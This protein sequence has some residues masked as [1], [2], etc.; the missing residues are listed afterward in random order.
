MRLILNFLGV[1][2]VVWRRLVSHIGLLIAIMAGFVVAVALVTSIPI[3]AEAVGFRILRDQLSKGQD[4]QIHPPFAFMYRYIGSQGGPITWDAYTP[5]DQFMRQQAPGELGLPVEQSVRY[6]ST[7]KVRM[8]PQNA[9][10]GD[11]LMWVNLA[12]ATDLESQIDVVDGKF[13]TATPTKDGPIEV[14][15]AEKRAN[16][17]G[18]QVGEDYD[19]IGPPNREP[20]LQLTVRIAGIWHP[21]DPDGGYWFYSP[22]AF[23]DAL[24]VSEETFT[25]R[26]APTTK[27]PIYTALWYMVM[28]GDGV[29]SSNVSQ[30][31]ANINRSLTDVAG[32]LP[33]VSIALSPYQALQGHQQQVRFLRILLT[34]FSLPLLG[35]VAY[36]I[37]LVA[38]MVVQQQQNEIAVLRSRGTSRLQV[39]GIYLLESIVLGLAAL[40]CGP[41]L[42]LQAARLMTWTRSFLNFEPSG[43]LPI[44]LTRQVWT[45][46]A[47]VVTLALLSSLLPALIA[48]RFTIVSYKL[49]RARSVRPP[50][51]QRLFLD[52]LLLVP[53]YYGYRQLA[54]RGTISFLGVNAPGGDP[55]QNPLLLLVPTL[56]VFALALVSLRLFPMIMSSL[57]WLCA[58][59]PGASILMALRYLARTTRGYTGP[60]MLLIITMSLATF[61]SSMSRTLDNQ[62]VDRAYYVSGSD[63]RM[64][65]LGE[66]TQ[67]STGGFGGAPSTGPGTMAGNQ[68]PAPGT[69]S[70]LD[71]ARWLFVPVT[72]YLTIPGIEAAT[73]VGR[74]DIEAEF[75]GSFEKGA[76][77]G[78]DRAD[79]PGVVGGAFRNDY[80]RDSLGALLNTLADDPAALLVS[81][82]YMAKHGL[83]V[84]D[85]VSLSMNNLGAVQKV[86]FVVVGN[87]NLFPTL[88][89]DQ[90]FFIGNLD[91]AF[92]MQGGQYPYEVWAKVTPGV[93]PKTIIATTEERGLRVFQHEFAPALI[94][95]EL[96]RPERQGVFGL[97][98]VGFLS[99]AFLT[100][101]GFL[102]YSVLSFRRRFVELGMLRAIGLSV[103]QMATL[104]TCE[105]G[106]II[107]TGMGIGTALGVTAS[108][109]FIPFLQVRADQHPQT[110]PFVVQIAWE[111][112]SI[113]YAIFGGMLVLAVIITMLL[114]ARMRVFQAVK[115][116]EAV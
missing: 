2:R 82:G 28:N 107:G 58:R 83:R 59:F 17:F 44:E 45:N 114:L 106:L 76:F 101:L 104:L 26:I 89:E 30:L 69:N 72:D 16:D 15:I 43:G 102:F 110:P 109:L 77:L 27:Q 61:T 71:E 1:L 7:D 81:T 86:P 18:F 88:Y 6:V 74:S 95:A 33:G 103:G 20:R 42:G 80:A 38:G 55:F 62:L 39:L 60:I 70:K 31:A 115:L 21:R 35:V 36:F 75:N 90:P 84:G 13:P 64:D 96:V 24:L 19:I 91:Y 54:T 65:D 113:I 99:S 23:D 73:R 63:M 37:I 66:D 40:L 68:Q 111:Q 53:V 94:Q 78:V 49:E 4:N 51:W 67:E 56:F 14:L 10:T 34:V 50:L 47:Q 48:T 93:D 32:K 112:I 25:S 9:S 41:P 29:R 97:L 100:V 8:F 116:G 57:A 5:A 98:S 85:K 92:E 105:Q 22:E 52:V 11:P 3:Y 79:L 87:L 108:T 12:F 46:G